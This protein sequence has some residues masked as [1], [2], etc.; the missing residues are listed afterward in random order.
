MNFFTIKDL[1][2]LSGI[3]AHTLRM[4]EQRYNFLKP[5]R[6][7]SNIR[8][9][10]EEELKKILNIALLTKYGY[11]ISQINKM[12]DEEMRENLLA[13]TQPMACEE[14]FVFDLIQA[15]METDLTHFEEVLNNYILTKGIN[16]AWQCVV[17]P[18]LEKTRL[19]WMTNHILS[20]QECLVVNVL[21][22]KLIAAIDRVYVAAVPKTTFLLFLPAGEFHELSILYIAYLL[23]EKGIATF[24]LGI[25]VP[26]EEA[27]LLG[28]RQ[29]IDY[30]YTHLTEVTGNFQWN[31]FLN[32]LHRHFNPVPVIISGPLAARMAVNR[33]PSN[34]VCKPVMGDV[35]AF[36]KALR[37]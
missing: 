14:R 17:F 36:I 15:M 6:T 37:A 19:L 5:Q 1:E 26:V 13:L 28:E 9:Y 24:Y 34:V 23:K 10:D 29:K 3:K 21:R 33:L 20:A 2:N 18:F 16:K 7:K 8:C 27:A 30:V 22:Q 32:Q 31:K 4:W 35:V 12:N 11:R 25:N